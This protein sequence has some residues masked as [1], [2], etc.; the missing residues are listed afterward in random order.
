M[1]AGAHTMDKILP[2]PGLES[3]ARTARWRC[4]DLLCGDERWSAIHDGAAATGPRDHRAGRAQALYLLLDYRCRSVPG[5]AGV[6][7]RRRR[8]RVSGRAGPAH[9]GWPG[10]AARLAPQARSGADAAL[11]AL[12]HARRAMAAGA[13]DA[14]RTRHRDLAD[15][16]RGARGLPLCAC[17]ARQGLWLRGWAGGASP[18]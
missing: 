5:A 13:G 9:A 18:R 6:R 16:H 12:S 11:S 4:D 1:A 17:G 14:G 8:G 2:S 3:R 15:L 10:L 7:A